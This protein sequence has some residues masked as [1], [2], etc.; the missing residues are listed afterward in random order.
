[1]ASPDEKQEKAKSSRQ[2]SPIEDT[3]IS[4]ETSLNDGES[5]DNN[6]QGSSNTATFRRNER[7]MPS[8]SVSLAI[9]SKAMARTPH[10][11]SSEIQD[12]YMSSSASSWGHSTATTQV[13]STNMGMD[14]LPHT[15][16]VA[17]ITTTTNHPSSSDTPVSLAVPSSYVDF[18]LTVPDPISLEDGRKK[19]WRRG[20]EAQSS[21]SMNF[22]T[23]LYNI[24]AQNEFSDII[25]WLPHGRAVR[26][27]P[28]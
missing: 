19:R 28:F 18:S 26:F 22:T 17:E 12:E 13:Q 24:L 8:L 5:K 2:S 15:R 27:L 10:F 16:A 14:E 7:G 23:R 25:N 9:P 3:R 11:S 4:Q 1:M 20:N 6:N 21:G